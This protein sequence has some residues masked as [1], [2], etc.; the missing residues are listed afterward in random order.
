[1]DE[2]DGDAAGMDTMDAMAAPTIENNN[3]FL[4]AMGSGSRIEIHAADAAKDS[5]TQLDATADAGASTL[6]LAETTGWEVGDRI[7]IASTGFDKDEAETRTIVSV[8]ADGRTVTLDQPLENDHYGEI[9]RYDNGLSGADRQTWDL[10]MRAEVALLSRNVTIQGD[11]DAAEDGYGGHTMIMMGAEMHIDGAELTKMGQAGELGRYPLHWH[12]LGDASG[13]YVTNSSI[14]DTFNKGMTI[15]G[16]QNTWVENNAIFDTVGHTYYFE[17]GSEFGNV[18]MGNLGMNTNE[19]ESVR[20]GAIGSDHT[21]V[22]TYWVTNPDNHLIGNHA[23]GSDNVGFW[24]LSLEYVEGASAG[25]ARY[26]DYIPNEQI[27]GQWIGNTSHSNGKD[28]IFLGRQFDERTGLSTGF[29]NAFGEIYQI[30]DFTTYKNNDFGVWVRNGAGEWEDIKIADSKKG[31][32]F[33]GGNELADSL[34]VGRSDN[35]EESG[36]DYYHGWELYDQASFLQDVHFAGF[37]EALDAAIAN[38]SGFGRSANSA[39]SGL[40]FDDDVTGFFKTKHYD[41]TN[42]GARD[43][44]GSLAGALHDID[45]S[46]TGVAGAVITPG[47][48]DVIPDRNAD[49]LSRAFS[50][51]EAAGFNA[52]SGAVWNPDGLY[53]VNPA[54]SIIG[55][56]ELGTSGSENQRVDFVITR[57]DNG[58]SLLYRD[59][60]QERNDQAQLVVDGSGAVEYLIEYPDGLPPT[61]LTLRVRDLPEGATVYYRF[62]DL[63]NNVVIQRADRV[64]S[65]AALDDAQGTAWFRDGN[66]DVVVKMYTE[67]Y[68]SRWN[69][70]I[71]DLPG[72]GEQVFEDR[73][74]IIFRPGPDDRPSGNAPPVA[75]PE[76]FRPDPAPG[77]LPARAE[78]TSQTLDD[79]DD[80]PRWS[81]AATWG[82]AVPG[83]GDVVVISGGQQVLLDTSID[84]AG[85]IVQGEGSALVVQDAPGAVIDATSDW[86]LVVGGGLFQAGTETDPLDTDFT[87]TLTGDDNSFD[88]DVGAYVSG[89]MPDTIFAAATAAAPAPAPEPETTGT[90]RGRLFTDADGDGAFDAG[91]APGA[92]HLVELRQDGVAVASTRTADDGTYTFADVAAGDGFTIRFYHENAEGD[93]RVLEGQV[94][95]TGGNLNTPTF[96]IAADQTVV[97]DALLDPAPADPDPGDDPDPDDTPDA[98]DPAPDLAAPGVVAEGL[99]GSFDGTLGSAVEVAHSA[100]MARESGTFAFNFTANDLDGTQALIS[101][102]HSGFK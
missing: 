79:V 14:H 92:G 45:G 88:L 87:L 53:W 76:D 61:P 35:S 62:Q 3:A 91:E 26:D 83:A 13:Q 73:V 29:D 19:T 100:G 54:S 42:D 101:K 52:T 17:D 93:F 12:M 72:V 25:V 7:A 51:I 6:R 47:I 15:H 27:P 71:D 70:A 16:T 30:S 10:D 69:D 49:I 46:L 96:A 97:R 89:Q 59:E 39:V 77:A 24:I 58:A 1:M 31:A 11:E 81:D 66:G 57:Q 32:R 98:G 38:H 86:L 63:P 36:R 82:G 95:G 65:R 9:D 28:G 48:V 80:L 43:L 85:V 99:G 33:W 60:T 2:M 94:V 50:G 8:S 68:Q 64:D 37:T 75:A 55:K 40:T 56:A 41:P 78:S 4:M 44:G 90:V 23:A 5:W 84:V 34:I 21:A 102:D 20:A 18:L 22:S 67:R 74:K